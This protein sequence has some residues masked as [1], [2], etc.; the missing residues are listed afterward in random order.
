V[1]ITIDAC[2]DEVVDIIGAAVLLGNDMLDMQGGKRR[3][4]LMQLT[5]FATI[6]GACPD[7]RS[8]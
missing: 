6:A 7:K 8:C 3:I 2:Q 5:V 4:I 1:K